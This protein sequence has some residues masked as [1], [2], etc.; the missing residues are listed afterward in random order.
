[1]RSPQVRQDVRG[2]IVSIA[3]HDDARFTRHHCLAEI[4][5]DVRQ[6]CG[7]PQV[8]LP[9]A[10]SSA[11]LNRFGH[12]IVHPA[13]RHAPRS[14]G[15]AAEEEAQK[16]E[17]LDVSRDREKVEVIFAALERESGRLRT[18]SPP[19]LEMR[20]QIGRSPL[21]EGKT[22]GKKKPRRTPG[23]PERATGG[24]CA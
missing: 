15:I 16:L 10:S 9:E 23:S 8:H 5:A 2:K 22:A 4:S 24:W 12:D 11:S 6:T 20:L 21:A 18:S 1:M 17:H 14:S 19:W 3:E 13:R 7:E